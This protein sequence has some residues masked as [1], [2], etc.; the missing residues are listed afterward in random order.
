MK[1]KKYIHHITG[2]EK[3]LLKKIYR[4]CKG[5]ISWRAQ[6]V[7]LAVQIWPICTVELIATICECTQRTVYNVFERFNEYGIMGLL[8]QPRSG[9]PT[10]INEN[11]MKELLADLELKKPNQV[12]PYLHS[13]WTLKLGVDYVKKWELNVCQRTL[14]RL[15]RKN[16]WTYHRS[17][18]ELCPPDPIDEAKKQEV[19]ALLKSIDLDK[20][21]IIFMDESAFY[22]DGLVSGEW[23]PK[24]KQKNMYVSGSKKKYWVYGVFNPH[25]KKVYYQICDKCNSDQ[26]ILFLQQL[27][28]RFP[29]KKIHIVLDNASFHHSAKTTSFLE[30]HSEFALHFLPSRGARLNPIERFWLFA[31]GF[32][33]AGAV[34]SDMEQLYHALRRFFWHYQQQRIEYNFNLLKLIEIWEKWPSFTQ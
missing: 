16:G 19:L 22:L 15:L 26:T 20:E 10:K 4:K 34:F 29:G 2:K 1:A 7:L 5:H 8:D 24:G 14:G 25:D 31:K 23:M 18:R 6:I 3:K 27:H 12:G 9:R 11:V 33:V 21:L 17:K 28:Q 30:Q 32:T 13:K